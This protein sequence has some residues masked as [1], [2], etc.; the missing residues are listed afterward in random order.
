MNLKIDGRLKREVE[1]EKG[2][3]YVRSGTKGWKCTKILTGK[4]SLP[5]KSCVVIVFASNARALVAM[6]KSITEADVRHS[7]LQAGEHRMLGKCIL[8]VYRFLSP[9]S[10]DNV[11]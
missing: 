11:H 10:Q 9:P 5:H 7:L 2:Y 3:T 8:F 1:K 4:Y 6:E